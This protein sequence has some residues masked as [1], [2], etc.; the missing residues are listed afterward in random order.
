[1]QVLSAHVFGVTLLQE[2]ESIF[3]LAGSAA[4]AA[5]VVTVNSAKIAKAESASPA[6]DIRGGVLLQY[7]P[8]I[9]SPCAADK[10]EV[11]PDAKNLPGRSSWRD[12]SAFPTRQLA[13]T[14]TRRSLDKVQA[15]EEAQPLHVPELAGQ[16]AEQSCAQQAGRSHVAQEELGNAQGPN[17]G[18]LG[19]LREA[20]PG[21]WTAGGPSTLSPRLHRSSVELQRFSQASST[22]R[23]GN[24]E[25]LE[26]QTAN[27]REPGLRRG[28]GLQMDRRSMDRPQNLRDR[29]PSF[30]DW[31]F[32]R[33]PG[34]E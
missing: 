30:G 17:P 15:R 7:S 18:K 29:E 4:I 32:Q 8:V 14:Q 11:N 2:R 9:T 22:P 19:S 12:W 27:N 28:A 1:M 13:D 34:N 21:S 3:G 10:N 26:S 6:G 16:L 31:H 23:K 24:A 20:R 25:I 5:G 33:V